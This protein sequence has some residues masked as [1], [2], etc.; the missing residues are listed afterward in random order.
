MLGGFPAEVYSSPSQIDA[1]AAFF[2]PANSYDSRDLDY[3]NSVNMTLYSNSY[4]IHPLAR[5]KISYQRFALELGTPLTHERL[6]YRRGTL[7]TLARQTV[8]LP[9]A[10]F[11]FRNVWKGGLRSINCN[12]RFEQERTLLLDRIN[13]RDDS[14]PLIVKLG[15]PDLKPKAMTSLGFSYYDATGPKNASYNIAGNFFY[16]HRDIAQSLI[17]DPITGVSTYRPMNISGAYRATPNLAPTAPSTRSAIGPGMPIP[18]Q[19]STTPRTTPCW[20]MPSRAAP[21]P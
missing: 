13:F 11:R 20:R 12:I 16:H 9:K 15:N 8:F 7:D 2:D 6:H 21:T 4:Y 19:I 18:E 17:Y 1:L 10:T 14:K 5:M 3:S